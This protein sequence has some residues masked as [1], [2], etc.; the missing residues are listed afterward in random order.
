VTLDVVPT[1]AIPDDFPDNEIAELW[2]SSIQVSEQWRP[3]SSGLLLC[4]GRPATVHG[5]LLHALETSPN[6]DLT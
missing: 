2:V 1:A 3:H 4:L 5:R 6:L